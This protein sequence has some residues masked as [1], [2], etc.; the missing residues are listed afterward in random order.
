MSIARVEFHVSDNSTDAHF[1]D[2]AA[3]VYQAFVDA[4]WVE[5]LDTGRVTN[6]ATQTVPSSAYVWNIFGPGDGG[7]TFYIKLEFGYSSTVVRLRMS[8]GSGTDG[9]GT[10]TG[11]VIGPTYYGGSNY[12][13]TTYPCYFSGDTNRINFWMWR[14]FG[15]NPPYFSIERTKNA[16]GT[17]SAD[18]VTFIYWGPGPHPLRSSK[19]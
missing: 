18:G 7:G 15:G 10:L 2:W 4:G 6:W 13:A 19:P 5:K 8:L 17:D 1:R 11:S 12:G 9:A 3:A 14:G 16:D